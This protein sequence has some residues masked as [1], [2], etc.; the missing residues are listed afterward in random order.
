M[1]TR[2]SWWRRALAAP[3]LHFLVLGGVWWAATDGRRGQAGPRAV[4]VGSAELA[5]HR[6]EWVWQAGTEPSADEAARLEAEVLDDAVLHQAAL[7]AGIDRRDRGIR[8]RLAQLA[9][10]T[11]ED[12][13]DEAALVRYAEALGLPRSD[14]I[15]RRQLVQVARLAAG[16]LGPADMPTE[17]EL[18]AYLTDHAERFST[19][20]RVT[21]SQVYLARGRHET[22][23]SDA[24]ALLER[25]RREHIGPAA[26][27]RLGDA[28]IR[29]ATI[30]GARGTIEET[31]GASFAAAVWAAEAGTWIGP[32][33]SPF[34]AH[35][36][37]IE[38]HGGA[39][40]PPLAAVRG[41]V[42]QE[43]LRLRARARRRERLEALRTL[44]AA[45]VERAEQVA[46]P[47]PVVGA[48]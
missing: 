3:P 28:F 37:W 30:T 6:A 23:M 24:R 44:Y 47:A 15:V 11:G 42:L 26:A 12:P 27:V 34:G 36:V 1:R 46:A 32:L 35:L 5:A 31:F 2:S 17:R 29:G 21:L 19:P 10:L 14:V 33:E 18:V 40:T 25:I 48:P 43:V 4:I 22:P 41:R 20:S 7:D 39:E 13:A 9:T 38:S 8:R 45:R 16:R